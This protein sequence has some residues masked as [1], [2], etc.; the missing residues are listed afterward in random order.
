MP[1]ESDLLRLRACECRRLAGD[2]KDQYSRRTL[3]RMADEL[4]EEA[5]R[6]EGE[7]VGPSKD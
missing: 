4:D 7:A 2:A 1:D 5:D 6:L 3:T